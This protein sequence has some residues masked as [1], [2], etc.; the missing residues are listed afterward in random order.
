MSRGGQEKEKNSRKTGDSIWYPR[1]FGGKYGKPYAVPLM[2]RL[3]KVYIFP[4]S[5]AG[6]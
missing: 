3:M 4:I 5:F 1:F 6:K 2:W